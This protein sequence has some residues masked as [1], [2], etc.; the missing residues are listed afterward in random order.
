[1]NDNPVYIVGLDRSGKTLLRLA[2]SAHPHLA[3]TRRSYMW[4]RFYQ[5]FGDLSRK[6]NLDRCISCMMKQKTMRQFG[7]DENTIRREFSQGVASYEFLFAIF[8]RQFAQKLGKQ[9]WGEQAG[10]AERFTP[11]II[12]AFPTARMIHMVRDPRN[13]CEEILNSTPPLIRTG[14]IGAMTASWLFSARL[15]LRYQE[16][17]PSQYKV[18]N[19][20]ALLTSPEKTL[21]EI[22]EFIGED[23]FPE[24]LTLKNSI[25]LG[26]PE[27]EIPDPIQIWTQDTIHFDSTRQQVLR[28]GEVTFIQAKARKEMESLGY[29]LSQVGTPF[30]KHISLFFEW[31]FSLIRMATWQLLEARQ[32]P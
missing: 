18:V 28:P 32:F 22:C 4:D 23:F 13:R 3:L 7:L 5:R 29:S 21:G 15:A 30:K 12:N 26:E 1:M 11:L 17:Y 25:P 27:K 14:K 8:H 6:A 9:R 10:M 24:M 20:E 16:E 19:Y 2:L 31:P